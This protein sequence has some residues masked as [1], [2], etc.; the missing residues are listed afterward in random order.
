M[1]E[2]GSLPLYIVRGRSPLAQQT[3]HRLCGQALKERPK[4]P[5]LYVAYGGR[6]IY[7]LIYSDRSPTLRPTDMSSPAWEGPRKATSRPISYAWLLGEVGSLPL[8]IVR[9]RPTL[10]Q[11]T[12]H[13]LHRQA[14]A[15]RPTSPIFTYGLWGKWGLPPIT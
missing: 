2:V 15:E 11:Q 13:L 6:G 14:L 9:S 4:F 5:F 12:R 3:H 8:Y 1:G 10:A 7:P